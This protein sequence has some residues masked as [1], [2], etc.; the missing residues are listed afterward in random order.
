MIVSAGPLALARRGWG[1]KGGVITSVVA[2]Q[3]GGR[4]EVFC[5]QTI[6]GAAFSGVKVLVLLSGDRGNDPVWQAIGDLLGG[7]D[8]REAAAS[9][10][11]IPLLMHSSGTGWDRIGEADLVYIANLQ[12]ADV[13]RALDGVTAAVLTLN[14]AE[15]GTAK[16]E[17][18]ETIRVGSD[19]IALDAEGGEVPMEF[20]PTGPVYRPPLG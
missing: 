20:D 15:D 1:L 6:C 5:A 10:R 7:G 16:F 8:R 14:D 19:F 9:L 18:A 12:A 11:R 13:R 17:A 2:E 4:P 3:N